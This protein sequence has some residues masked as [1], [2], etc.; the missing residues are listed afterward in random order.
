MQ[1]ARI[2][3]TE[4]LFPAPVTHSVRYFR[5]LSGDI[6]KIRN[7][8]AAEQFISARGRKISP[9]SLIQKS[10]LV[11][12]SLC[13]MRGSN[14]HKFNFNQAFPRIKTLA[15]ASDV[16]ARD[17]AEALAYLVAVQVITI[18]KGRHKGT[19][20]M[21]YQTYQFTGDFLER[22]EREINQGVTS[23]ARQKFQ[24][25][26]G[27]IDRAILDNERLEQS[28]LPQSVREKYTAEIQDHLKREK[29]T[30]RHAALVEFHDI[31]GSE[32]RFTIDPAIVPPASDQIMFYLRR[33]QHKRFKRYLTARF[34][35]RAKSAPTPYT[36]PAFNQVPEF[37]VPDLIYRYTLGD[38]THCTARRLF[39]EAE[40]KVF[41]KLKIKIIGKVKNT[42]VHHEKIS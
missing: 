34:Y 36:V 30:E 16:S 9:R 39:T 18:K 14:P 25:E 33:W 5:L 6:E 10:R 41:D 15:D 40:K 11:Y 27:R 12:Q 20:H 1:T 3:D 17:C 4:T 21:T 31:V 26:R 38:V 23:Y 35:C 7:P 32:I 42:G 2:D 24:S 28:K 13:D 29:V 37:L 19:Q 22:T 8:I